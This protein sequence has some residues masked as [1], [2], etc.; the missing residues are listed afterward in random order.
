MSELLPKAELDRKREKLLSR[1][2]K[3]YDITTQEY[4]IGPL[5]V[6]FTRV[7]NADTVL[8]QVCE[9]IDEIEKRTGEKVPDQLMHM[10]YW[11]ELWDSAFGVGQWLVGGGAGGRWSPTPVRQPPM[12][13]DLGCGMGFAGVVAAMMG[14][15]VV[16]AD[17]EVPALLF[18]KINS[19]PWLKRVR[20]QQLN[21]Q[22]DALD[23]KFDL[24]IGA[25]VL[26]ERSQWQFLEPFF[27]SHLAE[28]GIVLLGEPGRQT[29]DD[30]GA[31][32]TDKGWRL[33]IVEEKVITRERP[34]RLFEL[35]LP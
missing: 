4:L 24:L 9:E 34:I 21:W 22:T 28:E 15:R 14:H 3:K 23:E 5:R 25:D 33:N 29:G 19:L 12:T 7:V 32:I 31:W 16:F 8:D 2:R 20:C 18:A 11:A 13:L 1:L 35:R 6:P 30:F 26:Y 27:R 17:L 10:P